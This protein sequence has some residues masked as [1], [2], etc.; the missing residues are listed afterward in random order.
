MLVFA[1]NTPFIPK[2]TESAT[3]VCYLVVVLHGLIELQRPTRLLSANK[4]SIPQKLHKE[5]IRPPKR[6]Q[7]ALH[8]A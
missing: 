5:L 8:H 1:Y 4:V 6:E 2:K 7:R 3:I